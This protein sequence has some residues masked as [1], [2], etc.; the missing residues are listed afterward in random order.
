MSQAA[1]QSAAPAHT[2]QALHALFA[3]WDTKNYDTAKYFGAAIGTLIGIFIAAHWTHIL[4]ERLSRSSSTAHLATRSLSL[5]SRR[6]CSDKVLGCVTV[7]PAKVLLVLVYTGINATLSFYDRPDKAP[8]IT[9]L[10]RRFGWLAL[11]NICL[12]V[13]LGLKNTPLSPLAGYSFDSLNVLH[14]CTGYTVVLFTVLHAVI[15]IAGLAKA[16]A[17]YVLRTPSQAAGI[18]AALALLSLF[19]TAIGALRRRRYELFYASHQIL[20]A[21]ILVAVGLHRP[22]LA[23]KALIVT[24]CAAGLWFVDQSLRIS[25]WFYYGVGNHCTLTALAH[26]ATR[27]TMHRGIRARPG[28]HAFVWIPGV[29]SFQRHP[30]TLVSTDP[31]EFVIKARDGFS[32]AL[33]EHACQFPRGKFRASVDGPYGQVPNLTGYQKLV[34]IAGGSGATFTIALALDWARQSRA[35]GAYQSLDF[36]WVIRHAEALQWFANDLAELQAHPRISV[37]LFVTSPVLERREAREKSYDS[38]FL[39]MSPTSPSVMADMEKWS[40]KHISSVRS[41]I[42]T[43]NAFGTSLSAVAEFG[44]PDMNML[45]GKAVEGLT[46]TESVLVATCGPTNL[47]A[48]I[49]E[50]ITAVESVAAPRIDMHAEE[51]TY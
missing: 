8:I 4:L 27:V 48:R 2:E 40:D 43:N 30:F 32:K 5:V 38:S 22:E 42:A 23:G 16:H 3:I 45:L 35:P 1:N 36:I 26:G 17:L 13:F 21:T 46:E 34:F 9:I 50:A 49:R 39:T 31:M 6:I 19:V 11:C 14:R 20:A 47:L 28:S 25:R 15:Y 33:H 10:A 37:N 29:K 18:V 12:T 44:R 7:S 41:S 51:F 24:I